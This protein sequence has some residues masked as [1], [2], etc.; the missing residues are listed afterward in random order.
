MTTYEWPELISLWSQGKLDTNQLIGQALQW[1]R[2]LY[3]ATTACQQ[4]HSRLVR[5]L[6]AGQTK[7]AVLEQDVA[8]LQQRV[9]ALEA[10]LSPKAK[11]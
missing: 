2:R 8:V 1:G 4:E 11:G 9:E 3:T 10:M 7:Q 6:V 5:Q